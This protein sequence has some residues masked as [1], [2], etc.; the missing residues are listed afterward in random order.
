MPEAMQQRTSKGLGVH[1]LQL[2]LLAQSWLSFISFPSG[3]TVTMT[4]GQAV[5]AVQQ[6]THQP[7][8][9]CDEGPV[10]VFDAR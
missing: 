7:A 2:K 5:L 10:F 6:A 1:I 8:V 9:L 4:E 3:G